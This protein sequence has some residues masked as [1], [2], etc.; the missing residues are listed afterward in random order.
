[1]I[2]SRV[3]LLVLLAGCVSGPNLDGEM[4]YETLAEYGLFSGDPGLLEPASG[5]LLFEPVAPLWS[6]GAAKHRHLVLPEGEAATFDAAGVWQFPER[7]VIAKTFGPSDGR[8][9]ET[10]LLLRLDSDWEAVTYLWDEAGEDAH[11]VDD[12]DVLSVDLGQ[13]EQDNV[14]PSQ[15]ECGWCHDRDGQS[16][17]LAITGPQA[18]RPVERDGAPV[19]QIDW[20]AEQGLFGD[21]AVDGS[22]VEPLVD[23][24]ADGDLGPRARSYLD[25]NCA[26]CH[27]AGARADVGGL[28]LA[29][30]ETDLGSL[31]LCRPPS[32]GGAG[33]GGRADVIV[34]GDPDASVL[35]FRM[36]AGSAGIRMP[37]KFTRLIDA[38]G[39]ALVREWIAGMS[40]VGCD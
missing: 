28:R 10:R 13:G 15:V 20:L 19:D 7:S 11:R 39:A 5:V 14:V 30:T 6:D 27:R 23:P 40:P 38:E 1:M 37:E 2:F 34:P 31:G 35:V 22:A 4:P 18:L 17:L 12:G 32:V 16:H 24:Y 26:H 29:A 9:V 21:A 3:V 25:V 8:P 33:A 36:E